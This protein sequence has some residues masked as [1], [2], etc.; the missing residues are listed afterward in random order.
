MRTGSTG[1]WGRS[2]ARRLAL[3]AA[4]AAATA[5]PTKVAAQDRRLAARLDSA[6]A[7]AVTRLAD[8]VRAVGLPSDPL[9][10]VA[11]EGASR[12]ASSERILA[13]V[14]EYAA[15]LGVAR[16]TLGDSATSDEIV[17]AAGVLVA[18]VAPRVVV[19]YRSARPAGALTVPFVVLADLIA[20]GIPADTAAGALGAALRNG[21]S[22]DDLVEFR[23]RVERDIAAGAR[24]TTAMTI[25][26][27]DLPGTPMEG[28]SPMRPKSPRLRRPFP[29]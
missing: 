9:I 2:S 21:A 20:R 29:R 11:L 24:P 17:S 16:Q 19:D 18:G 25:R 8:S 28:V 3:A 10:G 26:R 4:M 5:A 7:G 27:R 14:R 13:A 6:T 1:L 22:D 15:A 12:R 23:R